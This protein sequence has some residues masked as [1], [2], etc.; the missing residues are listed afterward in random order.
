MNKSQLASRY[1]FINIVCIIEIIFQHT[2]KNLFKNVNYRSYTK[3]YFYD[4]NFH[5]LFF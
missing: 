4:D 1:V 2:H 5:E 3:K